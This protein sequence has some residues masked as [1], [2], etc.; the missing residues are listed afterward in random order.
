MHCIGI[1]GKNAVISIAIWKPHLLTFES[2]S[3]Y[4]RTNFNFHENENESKQQNANPNY[5]VKTEQRSGEE[6]KSFVF[7]LPACRWIDTGITAWASWYYWVTTIDN[8]SLAD[9]KC[10]Q[11]VQIVALSWIVRAIRQRTYT[12]TLMIWN[13]KKKMKERREQGEAN[14]TKMYFIKWYSIVIIVIKC[15]TYATDDQ[16]LLLLLL[17]F[18]NIKLNAI[19]NPSGLVL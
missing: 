7:V 3:K 10:A 12:R 8:R 18:P 6:A 9:W 4:T 16:T 2:L 15:A 1:I 5:G 11:T 13:C 19:I 17:I 14:E